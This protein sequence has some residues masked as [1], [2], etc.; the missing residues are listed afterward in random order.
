[1]IAMK[2]WA[3]LW[4]SGIRKQFTQE[5]RGRQKL[6]AGLKATAGVKRGKGWDWLDL[7]A[8]SAH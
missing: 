5:K 6:K 4:T 3:E 2:I 1:M 8:A 7:E